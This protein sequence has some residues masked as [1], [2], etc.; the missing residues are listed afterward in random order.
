MITKGG[1]AISKPT[2]ELGDC[3][4]ALRFTTKDGFKLGGWVHVRRNDYKNG[5]LTPDRIEALKTWV[6]L[7]PAR[8]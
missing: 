6:H 1:S 3:P 8:G 2:T 7:G 5:R 4:G